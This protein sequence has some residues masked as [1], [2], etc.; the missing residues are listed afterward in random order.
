[1][2]LATSSPWSKDGSGTLDRQNML[3]ACGGLG[4]RWWCIMHKRFIQSNWLHRNASP[5]LTRYFWKLSSSDCVFNPISKPD[6]IVTD[7]PDWYPPIYPSQSLVICLEHIQ[8][9][10][11]LQCLATFTGALWRL[12][13]RRRSRFRFDFRFD[14]VTQLTMWRSWRWVVEVFTTAAQSTNSCRS[15]MQMATWF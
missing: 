1:M 11:A 15:S 10:V 3:W 2:H 14:D 4:W 9:W 7:Y 8:G 13:L 6:V 12:H 5:E